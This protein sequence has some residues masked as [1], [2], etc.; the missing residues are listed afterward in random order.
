VCDIY[1][2]I[3]TSEDGRFSMIRTRSFDGP[4]VAPN[5]NSTFYVANIS[6]FES[7]GVTNKL[8]LIPVISRRNTP[9][10][11]SFVCNPRESFSISLV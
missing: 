1:R 3:E 4:R 7:F 2:D 6:K 11:V 8:Q 5:T 9:A 10:L